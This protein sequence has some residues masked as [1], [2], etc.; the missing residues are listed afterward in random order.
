MKRIIILLLM[1][2]ILPSFPLVLAHNEDDINYDGHHE[3]MMYGG[4]GIFGFMVIF[5]LL[6]WT[7]IIIAL[8]LFILWLIKELSKENKPR[9]KNEKS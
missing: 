2:I 6:F 9:R 5:M 7:L 3:R 4:Y 1:F 8:V